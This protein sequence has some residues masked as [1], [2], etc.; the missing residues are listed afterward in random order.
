[1][2]ARIVKAVHQAHAQAQAHAPARALR[3]FENAAD[4]A[5][6]LEGVYAPSLDAAVAPLSI[7]L[8]PVPERDAALRAKLNAG[9]LG[10]GSVALAQ[11]R[12]GVPPVALAKA[13]VTVAREHPYLNAIVVRGVEAAALDD[14]RFFPLN[15]TAP[16]SS[17]N[18]GAEA[19]IVPRGDA[20]VTD[21]AMV[22]VPPLAR[23]RAFLHA[24]C[25]AML[26]IETCDLVYD[27]AATAML[28]LGGGSRRPRNIGVPGV[29]DVMVGGFADGVALDSVVVYE[30]PGRCARQCVIAAE[31]L[32]RYV[33]AHCRL[34]ERPLYVKAQ[35]MYAH[36]AQTT[37]LH[38]VAVAAYAE[39]L[40]DDT[41]RE[42]VRAA[43]PHDAGRWW[44]V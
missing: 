28:G 6:R 30:A 12:A 3:F 14:T 19:R 24:H 43:Q 35:I 29:V 27:V 32:V 39:Q 17:R 20:A 26:T 38:D 11:W 44:R 10:R 4:G 41:G 23:L 42:L 1:V 15:A 33:R 37:K 13:A 8:V 21:V 5:L 18:V 25:P 34:F 36:F 9:T 16:Y 2:D 40:V 22:L 31:A 7:K